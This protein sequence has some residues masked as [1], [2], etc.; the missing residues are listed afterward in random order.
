METLYYLIWNGEIIEEG[1]TLEEAKYLTKEY[2]MAY[3]GTV[4]R[5]IQR[6][7]T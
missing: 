7:I 3:G 1:L 5:K 6:R 4:T 2:T